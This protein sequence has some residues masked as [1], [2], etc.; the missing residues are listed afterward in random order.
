MVV[1]C[2]PRFPRPALNEFLMQAC[3]RKYKNISVGH[4]QSILS[5]AAALYIGRAAD[6]EIEVNNFVII[7]TKS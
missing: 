4:E 7:R 1:A 3:A 6:E 2:F 5:R